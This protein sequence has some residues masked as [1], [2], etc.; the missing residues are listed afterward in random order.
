MV[1]QPQ[2]QRTVYL[3]MS[4]PN[5]SFLD[6]HYYLK[7][8]GIQNNA[9]MLAIL[10]PDLAAVDPRDPQL[11]PIMK[12]RVL[13]ECICNYWYFIREVVRI[14]D[15]GG[16]V[17]SGVRYKMH[18]GNMAMNYGFTLNWNMYVEFPRQ[19]FKSIS[20]VARLLWEFNFGTSNS[21]MMFINK[22]H[23]DSKM[24]LQRLKE[25]RAALPSY[26]QMKDVYTGTGQKAKFKDTV[27]TLEHPY[28]KNKIRT[29]PAARTRTAANSLGRG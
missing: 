16:Q 10:D 27:E 4:T 25:L 7:D 21:E 13:R 9:F 24:N 29:L 8:I 17:G 15:Q 23:E 1:Q 3:H 19:N 2:F 11:S 18:R 26:L 14:P 22:K 20:A 5:Q 28:N 6:M 12:Q